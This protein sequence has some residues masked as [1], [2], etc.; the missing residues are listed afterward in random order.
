MSFLV[1]RAMKLVPSYVKLSTIIG[2]GCPTRLRMLPN[3]TFVE[4]LFLIS[5]SS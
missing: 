2:I 4:D 3:I 5:C 1:E